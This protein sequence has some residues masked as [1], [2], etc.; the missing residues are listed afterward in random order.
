M[1][2]VADL[3]KINKF[4][5]IQKR[6]NMS[7]GILVSLLNVEPSHSVTCLLRVNLEIVQE[8]C[9]ISPNKTPKIK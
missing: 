1:K 7:V 4:M 3:Y 6:L 2:R 8:D 5:I 9:N